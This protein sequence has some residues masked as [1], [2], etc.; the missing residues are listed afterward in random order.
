MEDL[1][2]KGALPGHS[3]GETLAA[4]TLA[5]VSDAARLLAL[6][7]GIARY[8]AHPRFAQW[9]LL[10]AAFHDLGKAATGFQ[11]ALRTDERW[12]ERHEVLSLAFLQPFT[13]V[14][15]ADTRRW[16]AAAVVS[17]HRDADEV[18]RRYGPWVGPADLDPFPGVIAQLQVPDAERILAWV[19]GELLPWV[20]DLLTGE[21]ADEVRGACPAS[22][23]LDHAVAAAFVRECLRDYRRRVRASAELCD[24]ADGADR[25]LGLALRGALI[26]ADHAA[27]AHV[28]DLQPSPLAL[29]PPVSERIG[30]PP[31]H[32]RSHQRALAQVAGSVLLTAPTGS[33][34]TEA[35]LLWA[36]APRA[37]RDPAARVYYVLPY[38][39]SMNAMYDRMIARYGLAESVM[40]L[41]HGRALQALYARQAEADEATH[42]APVARA[43]AQLARLRRS[44]VHILSPY[45]LLKA[46]YRLPGYE[47]QLVDLVGADIVVDE[48]HAYEARRAGLIVSLFGYLAEQLGVRFCVMTATL[49]EVL[50]R[51]LIAAIPELQLTAASAD[52]FAL[53]RRHRLRLH[54]SALEEDATLAAIADTVRAGRSV[55]CCC[56]TVRRAQA[57]RASL[58]ERLGHPVEL[59]HGRFNARDRN[60]KERRLTG[61][62]GADR[63]PLLVATQVVEVSLDISFD[64]IHTEIAPLEALLQRFGRVNRVPAAGHIADVH[65]HAPPDMDAGVYDEALVR[66]TRALLTDLDGEVIDESLTSEWL[67]RT[68]AGEVGETWEREFTRAADEFRRFVLDDLY[69]FQSDASLEEDFYRA[70]DGVDVL[71]A[72][73]LPEYRELTVDEP[74]RAATLL[75]SV[76]HRQLGRLRAA[77]RVSQEGATGTLVVDAPY[78]SDCGLSF[79]AAA[80]KE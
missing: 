34:K 30:I 70:F 15:D 62:V 27:S 7:P 10:A 11:Q 77:G 2:A 18:D 75:V 68:Y 17:H 29:S 14:W 66:N 56:N 35:A 49:P 12:G 61:G 33:G 52:D 36:G 44:A 39:A 42:A 32:L 48:V 45:Q 50:R 38:Q 53:F 65:V 19:T 26:T 20:A 74:L 21:A 9:L 4:H 40:G 43:L 23:A 60:L 6:R 22:T 73:L 1:W 69:P 51:R 5:V 46:A 80:P 25:S 28:G 31:S 13:H 76:S 63:A 72:C 59:L 47:A 79:D 37:A 24:A 71:P 64:T 8:A 16:V 57:V 3:E 55:L 54:E 58:A 78:D 67:D 41:T